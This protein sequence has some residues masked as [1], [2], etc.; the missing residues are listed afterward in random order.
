MEMTSCPSPP[1]NYRY[2]YAKL[3]EWFTQHGCQANQTWVFFGVK[4]LFMVRPFLSQPVLFLQFS[5]GE[6]IFLHLIK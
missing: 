3:T 2:C 5:V 1:N 6:N 4:L